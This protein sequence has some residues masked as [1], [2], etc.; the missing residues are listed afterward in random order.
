MNPVILA[1]V[2]EPASRWLLAVLL[3]L[4]LLSPA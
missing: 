1:G 3:I 4:P 2:Q